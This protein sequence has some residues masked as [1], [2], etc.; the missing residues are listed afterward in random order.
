M[1]FNIGDIL[2]GLIS[3]GASLT[4]RQTEL[5]KWRLSDDSKK[6]YTEKQNRDFYEALMKGNLD[7]VDAIRK[8]KQDR[9]DNMKKKLLTVIIGS[10]CLFA[11]SCSCLDTKVIEQKYDTNSLKE[12]D[13]TYAIKD[14]KI[15]LAGDLTVT[16]FKGDWYI[17]NQDFI[18]KFN[19]NQDTTLDAL[20]RLDELKKKT[21]LKES[22]LMYSLLAT[23][24]LFGISFT[25]NLIK[26][27]N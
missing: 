14:Q 7:V 2:S 3:I 9:I 20:N 23:I 24:V 19:E 4:E 5:L 18:K 1:I 26:R 10:L 25:I 16:K 12:T 21:E 11:V 22:I 17:V 8:E 15:K 6:Y 13:K 27:R